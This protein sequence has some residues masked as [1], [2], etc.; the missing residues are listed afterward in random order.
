MKK[1][2]TQ[3]RVVITGMGAI[4]PLGH[5]VEETW[6]GLVAGKS[7]IAEITQFDASEL[8][9]R[10]AGEVKDFDPR[11]YI[12]FKDARR[13]ARCS[14]LALACGF[15]AMADAGLGDLVPAPERAGVVMGTGIGGFEAALDAW[16]T[17]K[18]RGLRRV[19]PF[20]A[21]S[22]LCNMP[23]HHL[24]LQFQCQSY[25]G[26]VVTACASGTQAIG[27]AVEV[28]RRGNADLMLAGGVEGMV[29]P[30]VIGAFTVMRVLAADNE[31]PAQA[32]KPFDA[33]RDGFVSAEGGE[34]MVL[35]R[36]DKALDR[37]ARIY[38]EVLG[39]SA[40]SDAFHAAI[41]DPEGA[42]A[43][44]AMT[45]ALENAGISPDE[46]DYINAHGPGTV[47]GDPIETKSIKDL[48]GERAYQ[49]PV[50]STK[51]MVGHA[52]GGIGAIEAMA[53]VK[54]ITEGIIHPTINYEVPDPECDLDYVPN[55]ARPADVRTTL[56]NSFGL[57]GQNACLVLR[58]FEE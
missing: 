35:E 23:A 56:S 26:T 58:R 49:I 38:A 5:S 20:S 41:P 25:N 24:S 10:I 14:H 42:G 45:W 47:V 40:N 18:T 21:V 33:R 13:M 34:V 27:E 4:T 50:S 11:D 53:C 17:F 8:P 32:C 19:N 51:S 43:L 44:R 1:R 16:E 37:G 57:G 9:I 2:D 39:Y 29:H 36:L 6:A 48:F 55:V 15:Q 30:V 7:G 3:E 28:I 46:I 31:N 54:T 12:D 52:L 22:M